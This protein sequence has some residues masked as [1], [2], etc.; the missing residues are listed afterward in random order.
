MTLS[1]L[2][3]RLTAT[4]SSSPSNLRTQPPITT[5]T[6]RKGGWESVKEEEEAEK[7]E[8]GCASASQAAEL[9]ACKGKKLT[10]GLHR[11]IVLG[12]G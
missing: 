1:S 5:D 8:G 6:G 3:L 2:T 7:R 4:L 10:R 11:L 9:K 12:G